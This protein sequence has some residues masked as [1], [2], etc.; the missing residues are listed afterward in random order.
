MRS[1]YHKGYF[2]GFFYESSFMSAFILLFL[3]YAGDFLRIES[4]R[5]ELVVFLIV[6]V[7]SLGKYFDFGVLLL[8]VADADHLG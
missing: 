3:K 6:L 8:F 5:D 4:L 7:C 2:V 1:D